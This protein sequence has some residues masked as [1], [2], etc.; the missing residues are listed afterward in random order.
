VHREHEHAELRL[1][2]LHL[3]DELDP[4]LA[5][6]RHV[7]DQH[8]EVLGADAGDHLVAVG[9]LGDDA[10]V[11]GGLEQLAQPLAEDR[12]VVG[13]GD[14]DEGSRHRE[15]GGRTPVEAGS[16]A[17]RAR[18]YGGGPGSAK[19][20]RVARVPRATAPFARDQG[21]CERAMLRCGASN[22]WT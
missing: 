3:L 5:R 6:H 8:V 7:E 15:G 4:A 18:S 11:V 17:G 20:A 22:P 14:A 2:G 13:D 21:R 19:E 12:V 10:H 9:G 1:L 16:R